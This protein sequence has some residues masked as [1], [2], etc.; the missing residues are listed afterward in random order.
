VTTPGENGLQ[1]VDNSRPAGRFDR[2]VT[3][4]TKS[5]VFR[6]LDR[7]RMRPYVSG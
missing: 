1:G 3:I 5:R 7:T 6:L 4:G 2:I